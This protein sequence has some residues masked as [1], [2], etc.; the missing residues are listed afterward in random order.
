LKGSKKDVL[1]WRSKITIVIQAA[2]TGK[3][4]I[5]KT[6]VKNMEYGNKQEKFIEKLEGAHK[7]V[8][9][10]L[11]EPKILLKPATCKLKNIKSTE[12]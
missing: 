3:D 6:E 8:I 2:N 12:L 5:N 4:I 1:K 11:I 9:I 7:K 10:K